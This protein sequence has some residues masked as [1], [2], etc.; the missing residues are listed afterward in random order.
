MGNYKLWNALKEAKKY[1]WVELSH[2][3]NND[4]P[5]WSGIPKGSVELAK[6]VWNWGKAELDC[7]IQTFKFPGQ[8]GTH[9]DFPGHFAKGKDLSEK[10]D[11]NDLIFP[12][13]VIDISKQAK[14]N[15]R[16]AVTVDDIK[17]YEKQY[18]TIPDGAFVALKSD[19]SKKW[20]DIDAIAGID[21]EGKE[22]A[23]GW[24]LEALEYIYKVRNASAN[25]HETLDTDSSAI[26]EK[27]EDLICERY[28]LENEKLQVE[29]LTN[30]DQ[31]SP[32][33]A[34]VIVSYPRIEEA[35]GLPARVWAIT[36]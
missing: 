24:S 35:T 5:Y 33:G 25:G 17:D 12:L 26:A 29:L 36:E 15:P 2:S 14:E 31:V 18:G 13:V 28:V 9:I 22:N 8:F 10:Y 20:P 3:L 30:L 32:A 16:Y 6:T 21:E 11:V 23:P 7:L 27:Y 19:W 34:I 4:S 1:R